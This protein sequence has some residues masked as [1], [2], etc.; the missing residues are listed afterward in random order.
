MKMVFDTGASTVCLSM[1]TAMYLYQNGFIKSSDIVGAGKSSTANGDIVNNVV[2]NIRDIEI[3]G[4]HLY[5][6][7]GVV[8]ES[9]TAPLLLGQ[10]AIKQLGTITI[11]GNQL[12]IHNTIVPP[13]KK[14]K[15]V[16]N[17]LTL[18]DNRFIANY[19]SNR[20]LNV[21][22]YQ[23]QVQIQWCGRWLSLNDK[24][25]KDIDAPIFYSSI[26]QDGKT[27]KFS[28]SRKGAD[29]FV[30]VISYDNRNIILSPQ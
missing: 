23:G 13:I 14:F 7:E 28:A 16:E 26:M 8:M 27:I 4:I 21:R 22:D 18:A 19:I 30:V 15:V 10:T 17:L 20:V 11:N 29:T 1:A 6:V 25:V 5:N 12:I 2:I 3:E 24:D 9:L